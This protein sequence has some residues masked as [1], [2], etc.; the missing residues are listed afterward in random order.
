MYN[1][2]HDEPK[3]LVALVF[4]HCSFLEGGVLHTPARYS[5][6]NLLNGR[7]S[8]GRGTQQHHRDLSVFSVCLVVESPLVVRL[9]L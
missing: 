8:I 7:P 6:Y 4:R 5:V 9:R 1:R 3:S 2:S